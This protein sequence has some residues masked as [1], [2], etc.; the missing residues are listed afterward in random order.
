VTAIY[1]T[2]PDGTKR[3]R[4]HRLVQLVAAE[5]STAVAEARSPNWAIF[6]PQYIEDACQ[7]VRRDHP[8]W[9]TNL[10]TLKL[11]SFLKHSKKMWLPNPPTEQEIENG[12][13]YYC[14]A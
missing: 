12:V 5:W 1:K 10:S 14:I 13:F 8:D 11:R 7:Q 2:F 3:P 9:N 4:V 6:T